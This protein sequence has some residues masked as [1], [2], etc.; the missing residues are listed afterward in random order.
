MELDEFIRDVKRKAVL[1][2]RDEVIKAIKATLETLKERLSGDEPGHIAAQLPRQIGEMLQG[3][4][5]GESF[6][7]EEFFSRVSRREGTEIPVAMLHARSVLEAIRE[8]ITAGEMSD[9]RAQLPAEFY[10]LFEEE[11]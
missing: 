10:D 1:D 6:T 2:N 3:E 7:V 5:K 11:K 4:G 8:A 9:V